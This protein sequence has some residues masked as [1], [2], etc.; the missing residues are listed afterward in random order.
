MI[1]CSIAEQ[2]YYSCCSII[3]IHSGLFVLTYLAP[4]P[5]CSPL[6]IYKWLPA[7]HLSLKRTAACFA[8]TV[9][10][11]MLPLMFC[12]LFLYMLYK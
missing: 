5:I 12:S 1:I 11:K 8:I 3:Q 2:R 7:S 10:I 4:H 9:I 6:K